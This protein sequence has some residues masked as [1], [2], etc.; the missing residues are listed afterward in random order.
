MATGVSCSSCLLARALPER[1]SGPCA[2]MD[3]VE[4]GGRVLC[5]ENGELWAL[6]VF[7]ACGSNVPG[8]GKV[9]P[10]QLVGQQA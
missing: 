1:T 7:Q 4:H 8:V 5:C 3:G 2:A 6:E 10:C 9:R